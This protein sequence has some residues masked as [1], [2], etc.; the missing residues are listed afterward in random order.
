MLTPH[1]KWNKMV[2]LTLLLRV[3]FL[4]FSFPVLGS[5]FSF[6]FW[7]SF[8][9]NPVFF[10]FFKVPFSFAGP[11]KKKRR[12]GEKEPFSAFLGLAPV[13]ENKR[14]E[15]ETRGKKMETELT[16]LL[17]IDPQNDFHPGGSLAIP[18]ADADA[19]RTARFIRAHARR[20]DRIVVTLDSHQRVHI[21]HG[22][23]WVN[24]TGDR[25]PPF[26]LITRDDVARGKWRAAD[27]SKQRAAEAYT[28]K[29][30]EKGKF[31]LCI[32]PEHCIIGSPGHNVRTS[33]LAAINEWAESR[34]K[35]VMFVWKGTNGL[36]EMY[37][38]LRA[39]VPV[40]SL[41]AVEAVEAV[42]A[43]RSEAEV[44]AEPEPSEALQAEVPVDS[45]VLLNALRES[46]RL[47][48]CGQALS[49]CVNFTV[50]DLV[51]NMGSRPLDSIAILR[52]CTSA[53]PGFEEE[54]ITFLEDMKAKGLRVVT[55]CD[56]WDTR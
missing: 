29:L 5:F 3:G 34:M 51:A 36:T 19:E 47:F 52:D 55:A 23:F 8:S 14:K 26:T 30:E 1:E 45:K 28:R 44:T 54:G 56:A 20:I 27:A 48:V 50:R 17:I 16:S 2:R 10:V 43:E 40:E 24:D 12:K 22:I 49:H 37:S 13:Y 4:F 18:T 41:E 25:P 32:W 7:R 11:K 33:I 46:S 35:E 6:F 31:T 38:A 53:V 9:L 15:K 42:E 39:E 21:A